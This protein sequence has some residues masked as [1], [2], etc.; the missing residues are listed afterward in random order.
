LLG[1]LREKRGI[2]ARALTNVGV[3]LDAARKETRRLLSGPVE[4]MGDKD[5]VRSGA[6]PVSDA[7]KEFFL[8]IYR[9]SV[10]YYK[11]QIEKRTGV[12]LGNID[13][14]DYSRLPQ[15]KM[16]ETRRRS[17]P[18]RMG[19]VQWLRFRWRLRTRRQAFASAYADSAR[20]CAAVYFN[21]AIYV[22]FSSG[23]AHE[24]GIAVTAVH[25]LA[26]AL[27]ERLEEVPLYVN[28][29]GGGRL[30]APEQEKYRLLVEGY[31]A[32][33]ERVWFSDFYPA[34]ARREL[35][36][37]PLDHASLHYKGLQRVRE[38]VK[39]HGPAILLEIPKGW[40]TF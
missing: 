21:G 40:R 24:Y 12:S 4:R 11:P 6:V 27:W 34:A 35:P 14:W 25:E 2:A 28:Y 13:V 10:A 23:T 18:W 29:G 32:Y 38:L 9:C 3:S 5:V 1:L 15:H 26:H 22:S 37:F 20:Q 33:A 39:E 36:H 30:T 17:S 8:G 31:A 16:E 19:I 7:D